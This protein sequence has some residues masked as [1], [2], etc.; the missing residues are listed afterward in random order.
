MLFSFVTITF[1]WL[2]VYGPL[3]CFL[4]VTWRLV[5]PGSSINISVILS[6]TYPLPRSTRQ[7]CTVS[8]EKTWNL[9]FICLDVFWGGAGVSNTAQETDKLTKLKNEEEESVV[10]VFSPRKAEY[11]DDLG[12]WCARSSLTVEKSV[13]WFLLNLMLQRQEPCAPWVGSKAGRQAGWTNILTLFNQSF[14]HPVATH[15]YEIFP[16]F[17]LERQSQRRD[18]TPLPALLSND[19]PCVPL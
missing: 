13:L 6:T 9:L 7:D 1:G 11:R 5:C 12:T 2:L 16:F 18:L 15:S 3:E 17:C 4:L 10:V 14:Q 19:W 8:S